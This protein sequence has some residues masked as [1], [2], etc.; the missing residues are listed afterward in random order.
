MKNKIHMI[1]YALAIISIALFAIFTIIDGLRYDSALN[2]APFYVFVLVRCVEFLIPAS[3][4]SIVGFVLN[5]K[6]KKDN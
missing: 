5:H 1:F 3:V 6:N 4:F 2:S